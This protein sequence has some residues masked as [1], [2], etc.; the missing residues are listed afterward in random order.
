MQR[1]EQSKGNVQE[2]PEFVKQTHGSRPRFRGVDGEGGGIEIER[3][4]E[5]AARARAR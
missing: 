1:Q 2:A 5:L 4:G 3:F